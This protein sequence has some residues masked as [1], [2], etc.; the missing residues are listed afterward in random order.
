MYFYLCYCVIQD[1]L[2]CSDGKDSVC[3]AGDL[4]SIL[5]SGRSPGEGNDNPFQYSCLENPMDRGAWEGY[6]PWSRKELD[7]T[8]WL[9]LFF[10]IYYVTHCWLFLFLSVLVKHFLCLLNLYL[11][12]NYLF[13]PPIYFQDFGSSLLSL[14]WILFQVGRLFLLHLFGFVD[15]LM[16]I[17]LLQISL[18]FHFVE[19]TVF[20]VFFS[21][22]A[23]S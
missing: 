20:W 16:F 11:L 8:K 17:H 7:M 19:F 9:T 21:W 6:S 2:G 23:M 22:A 18:S 12:S 3:N 4:G 5:G 13:M 15:S 10:Y 14:H 1:F